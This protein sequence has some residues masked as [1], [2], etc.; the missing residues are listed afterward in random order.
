[1]LTIEKT[2]EK[3]FNAIQIT[4]LHMLDIYFGMYTAY[5]AE[6]SNHYDKMTVF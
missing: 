5:S 2:I 6:Y 4:I 1:M 3:S